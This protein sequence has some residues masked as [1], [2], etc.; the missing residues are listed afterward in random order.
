MHR[1]RSFDTLQIQRCDETLTRFG[2]LTGGQLAV[3]EVALVVTIGEPGCD[4]PQV[5]SRVGSQH[6]AQKD[7][8]ARCPAIDQNELHAVTLNV[9]TRASPGYLL[10]KPVDRSIYR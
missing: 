7:C 2:I 3:T 6:S 8:G 10:S 9:R 4:F 5:V 1:F